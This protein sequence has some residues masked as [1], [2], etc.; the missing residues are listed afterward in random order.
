MQGIA[1]CDPLAARSGQKRIRWQRYKSSNAYGPIVPTVASHRTVAFA[2]TPYSPSTHSSA[3]P[4]TL[5]R[6]FPRPA[7]REQLA[8]NTP[9]SSSSPSATSSKEPNPS[10]APSTSA[11]PPSAKPPAP[12]PPP[13]KTSNSTCRN[14]GHL[15]HRARCDELVFAHSANPPQKPCQEKSHNSLHSNDINWHTTHPNQL[16]LNRGHIFVCS[17]P[18]SAQRSAR[19][20]LISAVL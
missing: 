8:A 19:K 16:Q 15:I 6:H 14:A 12:A 5:L 17:P 18:C 3:P 11:T 4:L 7:L 9:A 1:R 2:S 20:S 13:T 10:N